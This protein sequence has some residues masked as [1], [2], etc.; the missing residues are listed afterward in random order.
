MRC[1]SS[2]R[3]RRWRFTATARQGW[4]RRIVEQGWGSKFMHAIRSCAIAHGLEIMLKDFYD[5]SQMSEVP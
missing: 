5:L 2:T 3:L 4:G 1:R